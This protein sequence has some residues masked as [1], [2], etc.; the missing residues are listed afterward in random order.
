MWVFYAALQKPDVYRNVN[1][2]VSVSVKAA[3]KLK[4]NKTGAGRF[5]NLSTKHYI[6]T[7]KYTTPMSQLALQLIAEA[8]SNNAKVL[9]LGNCGL[10]ELPD[11]LF[12]L[13]WLEEL[14]LSNGY[15]DSKQQKTIESINKGRINLLKKIN[16]SINK[17]K[18]LKILHISGT[19]TYGNF[20]TS[21]ITVLNKLTN[22]Q[23]LDIS[24]NQISNI[25]SIKNL[26]G[27]KELYLSFNP[28]LDFSILKN[29]TNLKSLALSNF[30]SSDIS[31]LKNL[32]N[33]ESLFLSECHVQDF[34]FLKELGN[35]LLLSL[36]NNQISDISF[37][38]DLK[39]L[40][41]L[42]LT[43]NKISDISILKKLT[44]IEILSLSDNNISDIAPLEKLVKLQKLY[45]N[46]NKISDISSLSSL[47][48]LKKIS[49]SI[50]KISNISAL[51]K[52]VDL[53]E[54][55]LA[56]NKILDISPIGKLTRLHLLS[57]NDNQIS[58]ISPLEKL[59]NLNKLYVNNIKIYN[60]SILSGLTALQTLSLGHNQISEISFL[61][62]LTKLQSLNLSNNQISDIAT[63]EKL[64]GLKFLYLHNNEIEGLATSKK[65][66]NY[67]DDVR[68][69][70]ALNSDKGDKEIHLPVKIQMLGNHAL[71]KSVLSN[72]F[73]TNRITKTTSTH[74]L[75]INSYPK[76]TKGELPKA[77][78]FDFGGQD[79]YHGLYR[80]FLSENAVNIL[81]WN[82]K[83]NHY[84]LVP[85][86]EGNLTN[87]FNVEYWLAHKDFRENN[88]TKK[89]ILYLVK[90]GIDLEEENLPLNINYRTDYQL[91]L[92]LAQNNELNHKSHFVLESYK[93]GK[94]YFSALLK[95]T[96]D[97]EKKIL[98][99]QPQWYLD[100][101]K[102]IYN[103][104]LIKNND[105]KK[106]VELNRIIDETN[107]KTRKTKAKK[108]TKAAKEEIYK[109]LQ[110]QLD[111]LHQSGL[112]LYYKEIDSLNDYVWLNPSGLIENI[113]KQIFKKELFD[114]NN[115]PG[116]I[117]ASKLKDLLGLA[118]NKD[119]QL[120][121]LLILQ[122]VLF[123]HNV[124]VENGDD[125]DEYIIPN[126]L[127][128]VN[129]IDPNYFLTVFGLSQPA[130]VLRFQ[131]FMPLGLIN[132]LVCFF[133][134]QPDRKMFWRDQILFTLNKE[135][136]VLININLEA[137]SIS[138]SIQLL[139]NVG[140]KLEAI[141][142]Y[143]FK[144]LLAIYWDYEP[145]TFEE[146]Y[147]FSKVMKDEIGGDKN[148]GRDT[149]VERYFKFRKWLTLIDD[150]KKTDYRKPIDLYISIDSKYFVKYRDIATTKG[151]HVTSYPLL[152]KNENGKIFNFEEQNLIHKTQFNAFMENPVAAPKKVFYFLF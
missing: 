41:S 111:E 143:L 107:Y 64:T 124:Q 29:L 122:K 35:L 139:K 4:N 121:K 95:E 25:S 99:N 65:Y 85:D 13:T 123:H 49:L 11:E 145:L 18:E 131:Q 21:D 28:I 30:K 120:I 127:P 118:L 135:A 68:Q 55:Y 26:K 148:T 2:V 142:K 133:G 82:N 100:F 104:T 90:S 138:V 81:L 71:G 149:D 83:T 80:V 67:V 24:H 110:I 129:K 66:K 150:D 78:F 130:F 33:L 51:G 58:D 136:R 106:P 3:L 9:D 88:N 74:I 105:P 96:I 69:F 59:I 109:Y 115:T 102:G 52:L 61:E 70:F 114:R 84:E 72:F 128:L 125:I 144:V 75:K 32:Y 12:Q 36:R 40:K 10:T 147:R 140:T 112:V 46:K 5:K 91:Q 31:F 6:T 17:L 43:N 54:L 15:W 113:H 57:L 23:V 101:L 117:P 126:F 39:S 87:N 47:N 42:Y 152:K 116:T 34:S 63:L 89:D 119:A 27:I 94:K 92:C 14:N 19:E 62:K 53:Q 134:Q 73:I 146:D 16:P 108:G 137:L 8:K 141:K 50:N 45:L 44:L 1:F 77:I 98:K 20:Q 76:N 38:K 97:N 22:L 7:T 60:L 56:H 79:F 37:L 93:T 48:G 86:S 103:N 151:N 132:Q